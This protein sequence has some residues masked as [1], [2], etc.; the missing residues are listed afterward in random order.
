[1]Q[2]KHI[3]F[4][5]RLPMAEKDTTFYIRQKNDKGDYARRQ[6]ELEMKVSEKKDMK[7]EARYEKEKGIINRFNVYF[8]NVP[9]NSKVTYNYNSSQSANGEVLA[10]RVGNIRIPFYLDND[11]KSV[12]FEFK[13]Q[14]YNDFFSNN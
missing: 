6:E 2:K 9:P 11:P 1:M 13:N 5:N 7:I 12:T 4:F 3:G 14:Y 8:S 10:D